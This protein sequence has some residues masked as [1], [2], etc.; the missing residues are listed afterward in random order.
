MQP[1]TNEQQHRPGSLTWLSAE[2]S[3]EAPFIDDASLRQRVFDWLREVAELPG[4]DMLDVVDHHLT[5]LRQQPGDEPGLGEFAMRRVDGDGEANFPDSCAGCEH[6]GTRCPVFIDPLEQ[7]RREQVQA[8]YADADAAAKRRAYRRY[9]ETVGCH[10]ITGVL[11]EHTETYQ[12]LQREG[13]DLLEQIQDA[14]GFTSDSGESNR[15]AAS[16]TEGGP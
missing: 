6:Y 2:L 1:T 15:Q 4:G 14:K 12:R 7:D 11:A 3:A 9:A 10:Q 8:E 16:P 5:Q 13:L